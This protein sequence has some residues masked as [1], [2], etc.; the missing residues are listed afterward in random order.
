V[1]IKHHP[2]EGVFVIKSAS[3]RR[4]GVKPAFRRIADKNVCHICA[5]CLLCPVEGLVKLA[6]HPPSPWHNMSSGL[7]DL[8]VFFYGGVDKRRLDVSVLHGMR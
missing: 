4:V 5:A 1:L 3:S 8:Y 6:Y 7:F 2:P